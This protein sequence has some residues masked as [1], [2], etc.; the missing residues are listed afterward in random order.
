MCFELSMPTGVRRLV[1]QTSAMPGGRF[2]PIRG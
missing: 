2:H 1:H